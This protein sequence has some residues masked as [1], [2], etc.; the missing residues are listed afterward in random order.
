MSVLGKIRSALTRKKRQSNMKGAVNAILPPV[1]VRKE[2]GI[3]MGVRR[4][5][6]KT[7]REKGRKKTPKMRQRERDANWLRKVLEK[8][9][10]E[11]NAKEA[12]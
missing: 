7:E 11:L 4:G 2:N 8:R 3:F 9:Y 1:G 6:A 12:V 5:I 10:T